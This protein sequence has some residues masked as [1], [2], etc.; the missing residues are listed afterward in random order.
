MSGRFFDSESMVWKPFGWIGDIVFLSLLWFICSV[1]IITMGAATTALYD[2]VAHGF[3]MKEPE[4][5][6]RFFRTLKKEFKTATLA[7]VI[8]G[9]I[10]GVLYGI[11]RTFGNS[12]AAISKLV[13]D[14]GKLTAKELYDLI[15][16]DF[17]GT[18]G[19]R[20]RA[21]LKNTAP[22]YGNNDDYVDSLVQRTIK[23]Y[24][25]AIS[26]Y[27]PVR[28]GKYGPST[29][30]LTC[31]V[32]MGANV[33]ALPD[34]KKKGEALAD[35]T[36]PTP[37]TDVLGPT[38]VV[39]S[40]AKIDHIALDNGTILNVKFHPSALADE[41]RINKF[42]SFIRTYFALDGFQIQFN[43]VSADTLRAAQAHPDEYKSLVVKVAGYSAF[44]SALDEKLQNQ[45]IERTEHQFGD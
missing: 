40:A 45:I 28:G 26:E 3:R 25:D 10:L 22:K 14:E 20:M 34:G 31:N 35:N 23:L 17:D 15:S 4:T 16:C 19:E 44:F 32:P 24:T 33:G 43:V 2:A 18:D 27:T 30:G 38:A 9:V 39:M 12:V 5:V 1:P 37:G 7:T 29:Q 11:L 6:H 8:W 13:F 42:C 36:S 21:L 41:E